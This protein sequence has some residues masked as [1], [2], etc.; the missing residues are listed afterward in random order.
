M[1][2]AQFRTD[3]AR[4]TDGKNGLISQRDVNIQPGAR[5]ARHTIVYQVQGHALFVTHREVSQ[6]SR[7]A[8][9]CLP[10]V[11]EM[12]KHAP[13]RPHHVHD[14]NLGSPPTSL[15]VSISGVR[16]GLAFRRRVCACVR[17]T[18]APERRVAH[19]SPSTWPKVAKVAAA[20]GP[21]TSSI[22]HRSA[23]SSA[24]PTVSRRGCAMSSWCSSWMG[25]SYMP[26]RTRQP[27]GP[28]QCTARARCSHDRLGCRCGRSTAACWSSRPGAAPAWSAAALV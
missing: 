5:E 1:W 18:S 23:C 2:Y 19:N 15:F 6:L 20:S 21:V 11:H 16:L 26:A 12:R 27:S 17:W 8:S 25:C 24:H 9:R 22:G 3:T 28:C 10:P 14:G 7:C 13:L 4:P